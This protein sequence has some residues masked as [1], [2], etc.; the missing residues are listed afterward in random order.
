[1]TTSITPESADQALQALRE[2]LI[3]LEGELRAQIARDLHDG[4]VQ[5]VAAASLHLAY[6][7]RIQEHAPYLLPDAINDLDEQLART[8][9]MLRNV[10]Y[11]LRPPGIAEYGL[12]TIIR[13]YIEQ[14]EASTGINVS[15]TLPNDLLLPTEAHQYPV[16]FML[17]E[18][19][20]NIRKHAQATEVSVTFC[21]DDV[22]FIIDI[23]DNGRG[24]DRTTPPAPT[25]FGLTGLAERAARIGGTLEID[26]QPGHG[27]HLSILVPLEAG[28]TE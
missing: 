8:M 25:S 13:Q 6:L 1:M 20:I 5:Q 27:T 15:L 26:S 23:T 19:L 3:R 9:T 12:Y 7:R 21:A 22:N 10:M 14:F 4:P 17:Q 11:E 24:F 16:F 2:Q 18:A 28:E